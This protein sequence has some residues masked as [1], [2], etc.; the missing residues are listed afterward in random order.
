MLGGETLY[1]AHRILHQLGLLFDFIFFFFFFCYSW[2]Y[3]ASMKKACKGMFV[4]SHAGKLWA[5]G[6]YSVEEDYS[7]LEIYD[8][9]IDSWSDSQM[10][11]KSIDGKIVGCK[12][13]S[14]Y[15]N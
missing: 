12:Y 1:F 10:K 6:G 8:A 13:Y 14:K 5:F 2:S 3:V 4:T 7:S 15:F 11:L 9:E